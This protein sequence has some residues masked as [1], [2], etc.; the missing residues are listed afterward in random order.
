MIFFISD[1]HFGH[2]NILRFERENRP[3][4]SVDEMDCEMILRWNNKVKED[5]TVY[6][7]GDFSFSND[8]ITA[9]ILSQLNGNKILIL[10]NHD[11]KIKKSK[12]LQEFFTSIHD[13]K[14]IRL[15]GKDII[16]FHYPIDIWD[17]QHR[18]SIHLFGHV[19]SNSDNKFRPLEKLK[20]NSYNVGADVNNLEPCTL[21]EVIE[22]NKK[23]AAEVFTK[24]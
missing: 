14:R 10:G 4:G 11:E 17:N 5:D 2:R 22:N 3:F 9:D 24:Q 7:L 20:E 1:T 15:D 6:I 18:G 8:T 13:Y 16:M 23:W 19:H 12:V 21:E